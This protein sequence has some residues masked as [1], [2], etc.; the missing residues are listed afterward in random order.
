MDKALAGGIRL[1]ASPT[2]SGT[3]SQ[4][5]GLSGLGPQWAGKR[6]NP[7]GAR[8]DPARTRTWDVGKGS[9]LSLM[10]GP[11]AG[12]RARSAGAVPTWGLVRVP[13][14]CHDPLAS[15]VQAGKLG[16][17]CCAGPGGVQLGS[18]ASLERHPSALQTKGL[19]LAGGRL[20]VS[21]ATQ[22][23]ARPLIPRLPFRAVWGHIHAPGLQ[24]L[25]PAKHH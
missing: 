17:A 21:T 13:Q 20:R 8:L 18:T 5:K 25:V 19:G 14:L 7:A 3:C 6:R 2:G 4:G 1:H 12:G 9:V 24:V 22:L 23:P 11:L 16:A 10:H 15:G